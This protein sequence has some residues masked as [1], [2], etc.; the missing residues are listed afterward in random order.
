[1]H[2]R[3]WSF[4]NNEIPPGFFLSYFDEKELYNEVTQTR[5]EPR[6]GSII[7]EMMKKML[8]NP[9]GVLLLYS[10]YK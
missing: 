5:Y 7:I 4:Y 9:V 8:R 10:D 1:M 2:Y 6:S 3:S